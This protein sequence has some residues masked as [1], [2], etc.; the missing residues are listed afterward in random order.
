MRIA[1]VSTEVAGFH[2]GGIGTYVVEAGKAL[3]AAGHEVWLVTGAPDRSRQAELRR[4][5]AFTRVLFAEDAKT[6][7]EDV[8]FAFGRRALWFSQLAFDALRES[9]AAF[10]YVEL[11]D[12]GAAGFQ[13]V[14]EQRLFGSLGDAVVAVV[15]HSPTFEVAKFNETL[16][17]MGP[18]EREVAVLEHEAIRRAPVVW[19]PSTRLKEMVGTRLGLPSDFAEVIRYPMHLPAELPEPPE[20]GRRLEDLRFLYFGRLEPRKGVR[21]LVDAFRQMPELRLECVGRDGNT[22]PGAT[23]ELAFL[24]RRAGPNVTFTPPLPRD[25]M[26]AKLRNADVVVLPST[27]ENWPNTCIESMAEARVVI[28]GRDGGMGEMIEPGTSGFLV[29]GCDSA[30][31]VRVVRDELGGALDRLDVIG[32]AAARRI[33]ELADPARYVAAIEGVVARHR[34][35]GRAPAISR[36]RQRVSIVVPYYRE[37]LATVGAAVDSAL[38]QE[39]P[40]LEILVVNDG[41]PRPDAAQILDAVAAKDARVRV[42][43]KENGGLATARNMAVEQVDGDFVLCLD[44]DNLLRRDYTSIGV[45]VF[46][47]VPEASAIAPRF[48]VFDGASGSTVAIVQPLPFDRALS[49]FRNSLGDAGAMFRREVFHEHGLRYDSV[50]DVYSDWALWLDLARLGLHTERVPRVL[51]DYQV[52]AGSMMDEQAW[53][54]HLDLL[55]LLI[56]RHLPPGDGSDER[57]VLT[58]LAHGWGVGALLSALGGRPEFWE[59]PELTARRVDRASRAFGGFTDADTAVGRLLGPLFTRLTR[60]HGR[61]KDWRRGDRPV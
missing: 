32:A 48:R 60:W 31:I 27:W 40:D 26:L 35:R 1:L 38:A 50:V 20:A 7:R 25:A 34:G 14:L 13:A 46:S 21:Q 17:A 49:I 57:E 11:A 24:E 51:Y 58:T 36:G 9:G 22:A 6:P 10:D 39:H 16:H 54:R 47:R 19:S 41:S 4:H 44:A 5:P 43:H 45:D 12:Y 23:S 55:G 8:R 42:L 30:D 3:T 37:G 33:R 18:S 56:E 2:G 28:G 59:R 53:S 15:L 29:D 61:Y 52:R